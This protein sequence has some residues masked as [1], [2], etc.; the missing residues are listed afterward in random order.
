MCWDLQVKYFNQSPLP[1]FPDGRSGYQNN[2]F[3][4]WYTT[5][6]CINF[7]CVGRCRMVTPSELLPLKPSPWRWWSWGRGVEVRLGQWWRQRRCVPR[8]S[9]GVRRPLRLRRPLVLPWHLPWP[10]RSGCCGRPLCSGSS[11]C[12]CGLG[13]VA[14]SPRTA[15]GSP[16]KG[17]PH[18]R[19][20][21][22]VSGL[23]HKHTFSMTD[24]K[25]SELPPQN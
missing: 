24:E 23:R 9:F 15:P 6:K 2:L 4:K 17:S 16:P 18:R 22:C 14:A 20:G 25:M 8:R 21:G 19:R 7:A 12:G 3:N 1:L 10:Q 5:L 13:P 11:G